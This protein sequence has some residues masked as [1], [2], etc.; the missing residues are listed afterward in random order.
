[1]SMSMHLSPVGACVN[2]KSNT[3]GSDTEMHDSKFIPADFAGDC[4]I[5]HK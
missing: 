2:V 5:L 4:I 1:M 3:G